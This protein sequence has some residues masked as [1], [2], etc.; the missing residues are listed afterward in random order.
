MHTQYLIVNYCCHGK[1]IKAI[2]ERFPEFDVVA[3]LAFIIKTVNPIY[4]GTLM[5]SAEEEKVLGVLDFVSKHQANSFKGLL[6]SV[7]VI[8]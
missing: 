1:T 5:V 2:S 4:T 6:A 3:S 8:T 7:N